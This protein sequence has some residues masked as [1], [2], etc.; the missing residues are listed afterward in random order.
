MAFGVLAFL[1]S[2]VILAQKAHA[3][4]ETILAAAPSFFLPL[5]T[6]FLIL[7]VLGLV[8]GMGTAVFLDV[9]LVRHLYRAP[10][11]EQTILNA[12]LGGTLVT[13]GL[14]LLWISGL[15]FLILMWSQGS[16]NLM[17]PKVWSKVTIV[18]LLSLN[19]M[20]IHDLLFSKIEE[21]IGAPLLAK[22]DLKAAMPF[23]L[24]GTIS[25]TGWFF[26]FFLGMV[27]ELNFA[28]AGYVFLLV[29]AVMVGAALMIAC[30]MHRA[31]VPPA[32]RQ[33]ASSID[34]KRLKNALRSGLRG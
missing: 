17:S 29:Y 10:I 32:I 1:L 3:A 27:R 13:I 4:Y 5:K 34:S 18:C 16:P 25:V 31:M 15:G 30:L 23:F 9:L 22:A 8:I 14:V 11:T 12:R 2:D 6:V 7:H 24:L 20:L 28:Y 19:G 26:S 21:G 33:A